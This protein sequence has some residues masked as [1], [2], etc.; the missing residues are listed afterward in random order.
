MTLLEISD[1]HV[2]YGPIDAVKGVSLTVERGDVVA[3]LGPNGAGK[4]SILQAI[5]GL[6]RTRSGSVRW[7]DEDITGW[8][9]ER[10]ARAGIAFVPESRGVFGS[11]SIGEN[12]NL[13]GC[14]LAKGVDASEQVALALRH[15]PALADRLSERA[16]VLSGG[17]RQQLAIGRALVAAPE[18]LILDEPSLGLAPVVLDG[19]FAS[20]AALREEGR[21][22]LLVEQNASR[23]V[24][25]AD[26]V[27]S[28]RAGTIERV[29]EPEQL[30]RDAA[31]RAKHLG[32][33]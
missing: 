31:F 17:E 22:I 19:L 25:L 26:H 13:A 24:R 27:F 11:L 15:F 28:L 6:V 4:S 12:L 30:L 7:R 3:I 18:L 16:A 9:P 29:D 8:A 32:M 5:Q 10:R 14:A 21:T 1:L 23:A 33:G 20:L 2:S